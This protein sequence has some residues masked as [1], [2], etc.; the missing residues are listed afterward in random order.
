LYPVTSKPSR[1]ALSLQTRNAVFSV[2]NV[3]KGSVQSWT[4]RKELSNKGFSTV[5]RR[6]DQLE[7]LSHECPRR[8]ALKHS[9]KKRI[10]VFSF[11]DQHRVHQERSCR[12]AIAK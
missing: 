11:S 10:V 5:N 8:S 7:L 4:F 3:V 9:R 6:R 2:G 12:T 1:T